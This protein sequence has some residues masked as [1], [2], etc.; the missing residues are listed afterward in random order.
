VNDAP[1]LVNFDPGPL[2]YEPGDEPLQLFENIVLKDVDNEHLT[3]AEIGFDSAYHSPANDE[4]NIDD[5]T[6]LKVIYDPT[7]I[8]FLVGFGTLDEYR[9]AI[10]TITYYYKMTMDENGNP[11]EVLS[12]PRNIYITLHDGQDGSERYSKQITMETKVALDIPNTFTPNGDRS[13]D[14]WKIRSSAIDQLDKAILRVYDK[15]GLLLY[16]TIGFE[17]EWD[18]AANGQRVPVDTY[19][20]TIDLN[21]TYMKQTYKGFVTILY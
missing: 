1:E 21:L 3:F 10:S 14:T 7:G 16:E 20:Y 8:L 11:A 6:N 2:N 18:G 12:G 13:N 19:Y 9:K 17:I 5:S 4:L 15:R